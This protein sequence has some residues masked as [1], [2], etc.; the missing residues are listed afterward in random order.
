MYQNRARF[1]A[2]RLVSTLGAA[3]FGGR[4][5]DDPRLADTRLRARRRRARR[6]RFEVPELRRPRRAV[7]LDRAHAVAAPNASARARRSPSPTMSGQ[8]VQRVGPMARGSPRPSSRRPRRSPRRAGPARR[9]RRAPSGG[10]AGGLAAAG[11]S[12]DGDGTAQAASTC[13]DP[14]ATRRRR[15]ATTPGGT[16]PAVVS[17]VWPAGRLRTSAPGPLRVELAEHVVEQQHRAA[18]RRARARP[19]ARRAATR[20]RAS[21]ARPATPGSARRA[22]RS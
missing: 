5:H 9:P 3:L 18:A 14:P 8:R 16:A 4:V 21:A 15:S 19:G 13:T 7:D 11:A 10:T 6:S 20:A 12:S 22:R 1:S 17:S 2:T